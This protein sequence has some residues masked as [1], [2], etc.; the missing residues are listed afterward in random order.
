MKIWKL[1]MMLFVLSATSVAFTACD[2]EDKDE[3]AAQNKN[4]QIAGIWH[5]YHFP[6]WTLSFSTNGTYTESI[7]EEGY[8]DA[9]TYTFDGTVIRMVDSWG[10]VYV[11]TYVIEGSGKVYISFDGDMFVR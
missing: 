10:D 7:P 9:G 8:Y 2:K 6:S 11:A 5:C 3:Q 1:M 4:A